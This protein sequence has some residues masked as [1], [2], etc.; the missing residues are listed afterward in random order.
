MSTILDI[1]QN[2]KARKYSNS[3]LMR[4]VIWDIA[5]VLFRYSPRTFFSFRNCILKMMG[6]K[7]GQGVHIYNSADI[8]MPWNLQIGDWSSIGE[9]AYIYNLGHVKI[10]DRCTVSHRTHI[11]AGTHDY[12][13]VDMKLLKPTISI[14]DMVWI[15][16]D[17]FIGPGVSVGRGAVIGARSVIVKDVKDWC[18]MAGNPARTI[19]RRVING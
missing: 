10:G 12:M 13:S 15:C 3:E 4:R 6:A 18:V 1:E 11:C 9:H 2:R 17:A 14:N 19:K 5:S 8:Y 7:I 16:A